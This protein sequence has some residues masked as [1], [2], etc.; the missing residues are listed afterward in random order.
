MVRAWRLADIP[1]V[2]RFRFRISMVRAW[3]LADVAACRA[4]S[5]QDFQTNSM[6]LPLNRRHNIGAR[7][8]FAVFYV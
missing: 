6:F 2:V 3:R 4:V 7:A 1:A 8:P 5:V